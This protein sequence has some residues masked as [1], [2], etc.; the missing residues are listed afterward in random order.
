M[1]VDVHRF[2]QLEET[3]RRCQIEVEE[4]NRKANEVSKSIGKAKD[5]AEREARKEEG[6][7]LRE[8]TQTPQ[9]E[10]D[11][12]AAELETL[13]R[14]IP[15]LSHPDA[16]I[17]VDDKSNLELF[18]GKTPLPKFDF[19]PLDHVEL[20]EKLDLV[21]FEGGRQRGRARLLLPQERGR[22]AGTGL[23]AI[24]GRDADG[25]RLH[26]GHHAR[27]GPQ[28]HPDR[29][30]LQSP[31]A[32]DANLQHREHRPEPGGHG[33]NHAWAECWPARRSTPNRCP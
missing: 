11:A 22:A 27:P 29:H 17:G 15:N 20:A 10:L 7:L 14:Q 31:R 26:A 19:K 32:G 5:P 9:A 33:R 8:K 4:L 21:D 2:V 12:L 18:R 24:R 13:H 23:A 30:R 1:K 6:R 28:R 16:P 25:R 3:R